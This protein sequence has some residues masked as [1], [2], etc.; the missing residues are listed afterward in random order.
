MGRSF[1]LEDEIKKIKGRMMTFEEFK[2]ILKKCLYDSLEGFPSG[3][4]DAYLKSK[5]LNDKE[6]RERYDAG[7]KDYQMSKSAGNNFDNMTFYSEISRL[8]NLFSLCF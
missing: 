5:V 6:V 1:S 8:D 3:E 7:V 2:D 4:V